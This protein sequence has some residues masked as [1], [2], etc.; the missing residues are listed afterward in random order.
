[1]NI[2]LFYSVLLSCHTVV[3]P[4]FISSGEENP[5]N[6]FVFRRFSFGGRQ[7]TTQSTV[8]TTTKD[9]NLN[10]VPSTSTQKQEE[11]NFNPFRRFSFGGRTTTSSHIIPE[12]NV[13]RNE[14]APENTKIGFS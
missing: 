6:P 13:Q 5:S 7:S 14:E 12:G 1:M 4:Q 11:N 2:L 3:I 8:S 10:S 9:S